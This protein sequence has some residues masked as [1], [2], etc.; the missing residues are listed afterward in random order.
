[1]NVIKKIF[2]VFLALIF[3][4]CASDYNSKTRK[5]ATWKDRRDENVVMQKYDFSC[6]TGSLATLMRYCFGD[7]V[8][9]KKLI[10]DF[11]KSLTEEEKISI[12]KNGFSMLDLKSLAEQK[13]YQVYIVNSTVKLLKLNRPML[14]YLETK[15]FKHFA[16]FR[17]V[18]EDRIFLADP[19]RG[20]VRMSIRGFLK[21]WK[22]KKA[23]IIVKKGFEQIQDNPLLI[24]RKEDFRLEVHAVRNRLF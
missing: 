20:N 4:G 11:L 10:L 6:G 8:E 24:K 5:I 22:A 17:G 12:T 13:G 15:D 21:E 1:M 19:S 2:L 23:L 14:V 7:D 16:V 18:R 9:E 3:C